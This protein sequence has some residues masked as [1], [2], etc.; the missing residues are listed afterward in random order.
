[1]TVPLCTFAAPDHELV[2]RLK[3]SIVKVHAITAKGGHGVGSGV[4]VAPDIIATNCHVI[5]N[6]SGVSISKFGDSFSPVAMI[7]DWQHDICLLTFQYLDLP[8]VKLNS[9]KALQYGQEVFSIGFPGGPPKPQTTA[10][11]VRAL[12]PYADSLIIRTD[13]AFIMGASGSPLFNNAGELVGMN[14]FKSP[15][16]RAYYY[17]IPVEWIEAL[18]KKPATPPSGQ[19]SS[20]GTPAFWDQPTQQQPFFMQVAQPYLHSDWSTLQTIAQTWTVQAPTS[21][22]AYFYLASALHGQGQLEPAKQAYQKATTLQPALVEAWQGLAILAK[23]GGETTLLEMS[24]QQL[25]QLEPDAYTSLRNR[26]ED[27]PGQ[28]S[29]DS[30]LTF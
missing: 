17:S 6:A 21:A 12:Y 9:A 18:L 4:V 20:P 28:Q 5:A 25:Q 29:T 26:L 23:Q 19:L 3:A 2:Y 13:A 16:K 7:A 22:E 8:A 10:G 24:M 30:P 27:D 14:T 1:M 15:G 11:R